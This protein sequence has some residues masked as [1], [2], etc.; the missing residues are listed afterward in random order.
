MSTEQIEAIRKAYDDA[1]WK[2]Y[3]APVWGRAKHAVAREAA[4]RALLALDPG[5]FS[6]R[7][8]EAFEA[9]TRKLLT[10][11]SAEKRIAEYETS[12]VAKELDKIR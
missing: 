1:S 12:D 11:E 4:R 5:H 3:E 6:K 2:L 8:R 10:P 7:E 9:T